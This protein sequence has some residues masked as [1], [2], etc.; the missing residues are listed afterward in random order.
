MNTLIGEI[1]SREMDK[2]IGDNMSDD[3]GITI[4]KL[5]AAKKKLD[6]AHVNPKIIYMT[7]SKDF[8]DKNDI[9]INNLP[10][11]LKLVTETI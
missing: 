2:L 6:K 10:F 5:R 4:D 1:T 7:M 3:V 8:I 11:G 9:D